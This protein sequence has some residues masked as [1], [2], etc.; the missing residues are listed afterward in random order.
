VTAAQD[1]VR[2]SPRRGLRA[3]LIAVVLIALS[4][5]A[6]IVAVQRHPAI[7]ERLPS[8]RLRHAVYALLGWVVPASSGLSRRL[9][10]PPAT[11]IGMN[12]PEIRY[13]GSSFPFANLVMGS[14]WRDSSWQLLSEMHQDVNGD[15][16]S[17]PADGVALRSLWVPPTGPA[18]SEI[19]CTFRG[20]GTLSFAGDGTLIAEAKNLLRFRLTNTRGQPISPW[21]VVKDVDPRR[22]L[23]DLDCRE[24]ALARTVRFRPAFL[25]TLRGYGVIR[26]MDWQNANANQPIT[27]RDRHTPA[28]NR[29]DRDGV[30]IEDML[31]LARELGADPWFVMPWNADQEYVKQFALLTR[32]QMPAGRHVYVEV[33]NEVW[34]TGFLVG[35]QAV[36]E[37][38]ARHLGASEREAGMRRYAERTMEV[39]R[40]WEA[41][42]AGRTGLVRVLSTQHVTPETAEISLSYRDT[43][44][45]IDA[46]ATAPY[47]GTTFGGT[48]N[49][50]ETS[51]AALAE[52]LPVAIQQAI[53]NRRIAVR[54]GKRYI[55]YEGGQS[56]VL[57]AQVTLLDQVQHDPAMYDLYR[58]YLSMWREQVGDTLCLLTSVSQPGPSGAWGLATREDEPP[59]RAPKLR[60]VREAQRWPS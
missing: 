34:N 25:A 21:L 30:S 32:S 8:H 11:V 2:R 16:R 51:L 4:G 40:P 35:R 52:N 56:L 5:T 53:D 33:G 44:A 36:A 14:D 12:A 31:A 19:R 45:H 29:L 17:L 54:Y 24:A 28:G 60:A 15:I 59:A 20:S 58:R 43:A 50:R 6:A 46:L 37:G 55:G 13:Y 18:G 42:F 57:P 26:F 10:S 23:R 41:A 39:M 22:P 27:W 49:T 47:F 1:R 7:V 38:L 3:L 9:P 48:D